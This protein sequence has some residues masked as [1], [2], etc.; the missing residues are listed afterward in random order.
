MVDDDDDDDDDGCDDDDHTR[1]MEYK[2]PISHHINSRYHIWDCSP[3]INPL[4]NYQ[5]SAT[6]PCYE[7]K[8]K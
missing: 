1:H 8:Q 4:V 5:S 7:L 6:S 2:Y 3:C